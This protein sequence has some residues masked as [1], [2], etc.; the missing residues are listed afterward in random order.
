MGAREGLAQ[1]SELAVETVL[2]LPVRH[3]QVFNISLEYDREIR[4]THD[5]R[6]GEPATRR[7]LDP[8]PRYL[9]RVNR[10]RVQRQVFAGF[11]QLDDLLLIDKA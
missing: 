9:T 8:R 5:A 11:G 6:H 4:E 7:E 3:V 2:E 10:L 1:A